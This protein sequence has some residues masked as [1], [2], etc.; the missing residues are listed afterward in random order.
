MLATSRGEPNLKS[1]RLFLIGIFTWALTT[2]AAE[3]N[4]AAQRDQPRIST[5]VTNASAEKEFEKLEAADEAG[6]ADVEKLR[7]DNIEARARG[8]GISEEELE[9]RIQVRHEPIRNGY[10]DFLKSH[11]N[12]ARAHLAYGCF[13]NELQ[14]ETGARTE[15]E[16]A[17]ELDPNNA[18]VYNNLAGSYSEGGPAKKVFDYFNKA[19]E[20]K[21]SEAAYYHNFGTTLYVLRKSGMSYYGMDEQQVFAK[22]VQLYSNAVRLDPQNRE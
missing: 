8:G 15:W 21:P 7:H 6:Q 9:K 1:V 18:A 11:P 12:H 5:S 19:I 22:V 2:K 14:D 4:E 13:L 3:T 16:R 10:L 20:L 17:L